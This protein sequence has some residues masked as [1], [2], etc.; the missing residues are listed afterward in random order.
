MATR[1]QLDTAEQAEV[2]RMVAELHAHGYV[3]LPE[4]VY[5]RSGR[6]LCVG[7][8]VRHCGEQWPEALMDGTGHVVAL[9]HKPDSPWS[10]SYGMP[11]IELVM[12]S[13]RPRFDRRLFQVAQYHVEVIETG[14]E[15]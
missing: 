12:V 8:R 7:A 4:Y 14:A 13:D 2:D 15:R 5:P 3:D 1:T 11:D 9:L 6:R 10:R